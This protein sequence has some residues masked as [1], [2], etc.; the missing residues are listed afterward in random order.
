MTVSKPRPSLFDIYPHTDPDLF[1][2]AMQIGIRRILIG[3]LGSLTEKSGRANLYSSVLRNM[4][5]ETIVICDSSNYIKGFRYQMY[6][7]AREAHVRVA[8]VSLF[9]RFPFPLSFPFPFSFS[10]VAASDDEVE[11]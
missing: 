11:K 2:M 5:P 6:C 9:S 1:D 4:N 7:A 8:T 3:I 10:C